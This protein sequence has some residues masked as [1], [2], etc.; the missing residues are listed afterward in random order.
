[1]NKRPEKETDP[2]KLPGQIVNRVPSKEY[3]PTHGGYPDV[4]YIQF[5][6]C[7]YVSCSAPYCLCPPHQ[8]KDKRSHQ[9]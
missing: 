2:A 9:N 3:K 5:D 6:D 4:N 7:P 8:G 1:M